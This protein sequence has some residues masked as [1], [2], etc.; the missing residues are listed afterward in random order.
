MDERVNQYS[1][2]LIETYIDEDA[3]FPPLISCEMTTNVCKS[4]HLAFGEYFY[5][6]YPNI[7]VFLFKF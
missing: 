7:F 4:F 3:I 1:G 5:F 6:S 2:Y